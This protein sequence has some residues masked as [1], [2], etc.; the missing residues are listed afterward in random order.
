MGITVDCSFFSFLKTMHE[1]KAKTDTTNRNLKKINKKNTSI[2]M[3]GVPPIDSGTCSLRVKSKSSMLPVKLRERKLTQK[4]TPDRKEVIAES[5]YE[6]QYR[7]KISTTE[8]C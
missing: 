8:S 1:P 3:M 6:P 5:K 4:R 2:S 7:Q